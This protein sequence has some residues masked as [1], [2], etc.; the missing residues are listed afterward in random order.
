VLW[1]A[2]VQSGVHATVAGVLL[3]ATIPFEKTKSDHDNPLIHLEHS[4]RPYVLF[5][6]MPIFALANGGLLLSTLSLDLLVEPATLGVA[7]GLFLGK[8]LGILGL[9]LLYLRVSGER[10]P[11]SIVPFWGITHLAGIGFTMSLF[12]NELAFRGTPIGEELKLGIYLGSIASGLFG[13]ILLRLSLEKPVVSEEESRQS[14]AP[15]LVEDNYPEDP[16]RA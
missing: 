15:F 6:I 16:N 4:L 1:A 7:L 10:L 8:P 2:M 12:I 9:A 11:T 14:V 5:L 13:L 3:A